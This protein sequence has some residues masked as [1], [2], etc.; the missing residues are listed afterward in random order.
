MRNHGSVRSC[1]PGTTATTPKRSGGRG[2]VAMSVSRALTAHPRASTARDHARSSA[3]SSRDP[4][5]SDLIGLSTLDAVYLKSA[6]N[7]K[8]QI[9]RRRSR[10]DH[11]EITWRL[12]AQV[13][14]RSEPQSLTDMN[15]QLIPHDCRRAGPIPRTSTDTGVMARPT[16]LMPPRTVA[17][18]TPRSSPRQELFVPN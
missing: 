5:E 18:K 15:C 9:V 17:R 1:R 6:I 10:G 4:A 8:Y 14:A 11:V 12:F 13:R 16:W 2:P 3:W 7:A